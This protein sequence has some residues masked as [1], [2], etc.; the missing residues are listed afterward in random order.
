MEA[1]TKRKTEDFQMIGLT[2][3]GQIAF[4]RYQE[5]LKTDVPHEAVVQKLM[6]LASNQEEVSA[7]IEVIQNQKDS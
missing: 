4:E 2:P 5:L 1:N 3:M 6:Q 7:V